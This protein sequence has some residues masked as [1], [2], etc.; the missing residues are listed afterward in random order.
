MC[1]KGLISVS[2]FDTVK[3]SLFLTQAYLVCFFFFSHSS[4]SLFP[5]FFPCTPHL[6]FPLLW[7]FGFGN[8]SAVAPVYSSAHSKLR[9]HYCTDRHSF[10]VVGFSLSL[11]SGVFRCSLQFWALSWWSRNTFCL[12]IPP[13][14]TGT[15]ACVHTNTRSH[16]WN[17]HSCIQS[18]SSVCWRSLLSVT[19]LIKGCSV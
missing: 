1:S 3:L 2:P 6:C 8:S 10:V 16:Q 13:T 5:S 9:S 15:L 7:V 14:H 19:V 17:E 4:R 18:I 11:C 12:W